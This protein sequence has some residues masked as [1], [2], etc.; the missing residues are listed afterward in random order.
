MSQELKKKNP[1]QAQLST[2]RNTEVM[3]AN[4]EAILLMLYAG[5]ARFL[6]QAIEANEK[7]DYP[8]KSRLVGRTQ[9]II[10]ELRSTLN[11]KIGEEIAT[12]LESLYDFV[13]DRL[14]KGNIENSTLALTEALNIITT[15]QSA[16]EQ[17]IESLKK[18]K[19]SKKQP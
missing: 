3:T 14:L 9:E 16:W 4:R 10:N 15:L 19:N 13:T 11:F 7:K 2:Y 6:R 5:A 12:A 18:D 8:E 17:A 1:F